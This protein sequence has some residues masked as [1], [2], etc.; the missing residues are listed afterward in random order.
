MVTYLV[1]YIVALNGWLFILMGLDKKKARQHKWRIPE[2]RLLTLGLVG[3]G[4]GG[5]LGM[6]LFRHKTRELKFKITYSFGIIVML[7]IILYFLVFD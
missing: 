2:K 3:G 5:L 6:Y 1:A 7:S 4:L